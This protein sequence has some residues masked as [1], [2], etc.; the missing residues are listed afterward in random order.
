MTISYDDYLRLR[1][2]KT[3]AVEHLRWLDNLQ[4]SA[5]RIT[6]E[7]ESDGQINEVGQTSELIWDNDL[8]VDE[9]LRR[10]QI[11]VEEAQK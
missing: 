2:L 10:M 8:D 11:T 3:L 9:A 1:G 7:R 5:L 4:R 6:D